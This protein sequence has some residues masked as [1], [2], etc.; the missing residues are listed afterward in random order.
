M[1][2]TSVAS[3]LSTSTAA[4]TGPGME[5]NAADGPGTTSSAC[6]TIARAEPTW[7]GGRSRLRIPASARVSAARVVLP[8]RRQVR[9]GVGQLPRRVE[10]RPRQSARGGTDLGPSGQPAGTGTAVDHNLVG[11]GLPWKA[12]CSTPTA[13]LLDTLSTTLRYHAAGAFGSTPRRTRRTSSTRPSHRSGPAV[14]RRRPSGPAQDSSVLAPERIGHRRGGRRDVRNVDD[15]G[16]LVAGQ[17]QHA[18][19]G[20][21]CG[22]ERFFDLV[23]AQLAVEGATGGPTPRNDGACPTGACRPAPQPTSRRSP[24]RRGG[25][26]RG[27]GRRPSTA[28]G[29]SQG[30]ASTSGDSTTLCRPVPPIRWWNRRPPKGRATSARYA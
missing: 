24:A 2:S 20:Q 8:H 23:G 6:L 30:R 28:P 5:R 19:V 29:R 16:P 11:G 27:P 4:D 17:R 26:C 12:A 7:M 14:P 22:A 15:L 18:V 10:Q 13:I 25:R 21:Q 3:T 9:I 1:P